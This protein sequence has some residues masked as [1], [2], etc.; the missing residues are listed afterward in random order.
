MGKVVG[1]VL[2]IILGIIAIGFGVRAAAV[3]WLLW[4]GPQNF[5]P[6]SRNPDGCPICPPQ[7]LLSGETEQT[8]IILGSLG[9]IGIAW[10][11]WRATTRS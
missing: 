6:P 11:V 10:L 3:L 5:L 2:A 4:S 7:M 1:R 9:V 8:L